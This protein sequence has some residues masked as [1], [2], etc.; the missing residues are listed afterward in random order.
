MKH[1]LS[2]RRQTQR[3][4]SPLTQQTSQADFVSLHVGSKAVWTPRDYSALA[5][6]GYQRNA[7]VYRCIRM[8]SEAAASAPLCVMRAHHCVPD[9]PAG[10]LLSAPHPHMSA[11]E[12]FEQF[13]GYLQV[14]GNAYLEASLVDEVPAALY[15]LRPDRMRVVTG[16]DGWPKA[17][18]YE[19]G[20]FKRSYRRDPSSGKAAVHHMRLFHPTNDTYGFSPLEA[21]AQAIDVHNEGGVWSKA[22]L[23]NSARPSGA[24]IYKGT[25]GADR[26]SQEQFDRLKSELEQGHSGPRH[27]GR[28]LVLEGGL[29]WKPMAMSPQ[30]MD[31]TTARREAAR[32]IALAFGVPPMLLGIPGDNTYANYKEANQAFWRQTIIPLTR[33]TAQSLQGW[34]RP[35]FG[36]DLSIHVDLDSV[37]ALAE[38]QEKLWARLGAATFLSDGEKRQLAGLESL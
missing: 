15:A 11:A 24:L 19:A 2:Q 31:F 1:W 3:K 29:D 18:E 10:K 6:E 27:A 25:S 5:K 33:K 17:W 23:D 30:D 16:R 37:P 34:L 7:I 12:L 8:I 28:P 22:L 35:W 20:G 32:E 21:A 9:D 36:D 14:S 13:Y 38:A 4:D 26:L